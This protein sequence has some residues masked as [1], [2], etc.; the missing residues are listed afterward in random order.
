MV[1]D[2]YSLRAKRYASDVVSGKITASRYVKLACQRFLNDL[3]TDGRWYY[4]EKHANH[5]CAFMTN[6]I[7]HVKGPKAGQLLELE[8][9]Q[10][11]CLCNIYGWRDDNGIRRFQYVILQV[12]RKNGKTIFA[13]GMALYDMLFGEDGGEVYSLATK[14]DQ[15][16]LAWDGTK[17]MLSKSVPKVK[18]QFKVVTN[19]ITNQ[20][21][22][23]KYVPLGRDSK[24]LDGLNPSL[25]IYDEAAAYSDRNLVEV[26]TSA[27]CLLYTSPSPRD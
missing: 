21:K 22:W 18:E 2:N 17:Q 8:D 5:V 16:K 19:Q 3:D 11:F 6:G 14:M 4:S 1:S 26:M 7:R 15:A 27:T 24:S 23:S 12:A 10:C 20:R 9:W 13:S 25:C